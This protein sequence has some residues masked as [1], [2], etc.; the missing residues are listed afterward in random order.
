MN[1]VL[2]FSAARVTDLK[3]VEA[4]LDIFQRHGHSEVSLDY[5]ELFRRLSIHTCDALADRHGKDIHEG[6][7]RGI[8][9][10][11]W[12]EGAW[13][14]YGHEALPHD[15]LGT[16]HVSPSRVCMAMYL[17]NLVGL[18]IPRQS[19]HGRCRP[20]LTLARGEPFCHAM[21]WLDPINLFRC[22]TCGS[23][24]TRHSRRF[25]LSMWLS[26]PPMSSS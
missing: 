6:N 11:N 14:R 1:N 21:R 5:E 9:R 18:G 20:D 22:R 24:W 15:S 4:I 12:L 2:A 7:E 10:Q 13:A 25:R 17:W 8:S 3:E 26:S 23:T 16:F 19:A